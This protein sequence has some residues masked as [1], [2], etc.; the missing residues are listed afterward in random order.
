MC[1]DRPEKR[2]GA[3]ASRCRTTGKETSYVA[4]G[5][6]AG[7]VIAAMLRDLLVKHLFEFMLDLGLVLPLLAKEFLCCWH[8]TMLAIPDQ[9]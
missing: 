9:I 4:S 3:A 8:Q 6:L 7:R 2:A 5:G 1:R